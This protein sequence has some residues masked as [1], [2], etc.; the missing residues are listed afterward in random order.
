MNDIESAHYDRDGLRVDPP[1]AADVPVESGGQGDGVSPE[2]ACALT[3][4][5]SIDGG[6]FSRIRKISIVDAGAT[7]ITVYLAVKGAVATVLGWQ[8][9]DVLAEHAV[10][11]HGYNDLVYGLSAGVG[12]VLSSATFWTLMTM[13]GIRA[14]ARKILSNRPCEENAD[15]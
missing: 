5:P 3:A 14:A 4:V 7:T 1:E 12:T 11:F 2:D 15:A 13:L 8:Y 9:S 10:D 6:L